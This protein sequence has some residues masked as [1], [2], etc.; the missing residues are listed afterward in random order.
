MAEIAVTDAERLNRILAGDEAAFGALVEH[1]QMMLLNYAYRM[2]GD[3][4]LAEDL[5][6]EVFVALYL[7]LDRL[8]PIRHLPALLFRMTTNRCLNAKRSRARRREV[9]LNL[10]PGGG[11]S[12]SIPIQMVLAETDNAAEAAISAQELTELVLD[13]LDELPGRQ[14]S[15]WVLKV[16]EQRPTREIADILE[17]S[18]GNAE[19]LVHRAGKKLA[20]SPLLQ[21]F[22]GP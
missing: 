3:R 4:Q 15:A 13:A 17:T 16:L 8:M 14:R 21:R 1:F 18:V 9:P 5:V 20:E 10:R 6:Q 19:V 7:E 12:T 22:L 2:V 11:G